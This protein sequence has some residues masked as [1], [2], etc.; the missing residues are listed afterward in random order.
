[1][2]AAA[3]HGAR[4]T[5][6]RLVQSSA[7][8]AAVTGLLF[9]AVF[10]AR[11]LVYAPDDG[12]G[13]LFCL[14][15]AF[16]AIRFGWRGGLASGLTAFLLFV[17]WAVNHDVAP[18]NLLPRLI[19]FLTL[20]VAVGYFAQSRNE[21]DRRHRRLW[22]LS[23]DA[24]LVCDSNGTV[25]AANS[26]AREL[27]PA[28]G[29]HLSAG[30][31]IQQLAGRAGRA[32]G[33][34]VSAE[35]YHP[36]NS[37]DG[38]EKWMSWHAV[39]DPLSAESYLV[40]RDVTDLHRA[41][42]RIHELLVAASAAADRERTQIAGELHDFVLQQL[43]MG[44]L[45]L[46][47]YARPTADLSVASTSDEPVDAAVSLIRAA[48]ESLRSIMLGIA[49]LDLEHMPLSDA[50]RESAAHLEQ[51]YGTR[52]ELHLTDIDSVPAEM[53]VALYRLIVEAMRNAQRHANASVIV[54]SAT[55]ADGALRMDVRD[56]GNGRAGEGST[57]TDSGIGMTLMQHATA[58]L[59]GQ[60]TVESQPGS[61]SSIQITIP[62][63]R[64][65]GAR[66][67]ST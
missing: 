35:T 44:L 32:P 34:P 22:E 58:S 25:R 14:P 11:L 54:V 9:A 40:G 18:A 10:A 30:T 49:P 45:A 64:S 57:T 23:A 15:V 66:I 26:S 1:M 6:T 16:S 31:A 46:S 42:M 62:L 3:T 33:T 24:M 55:C 51:L 21:L 65:A 20:G 2:T 27:H 50:L 56:D 13:L 61:G 38:G 60:L 8:A 7:A 36:A 12:I 29:T 67:G 19:V 53:R 17:I 5:A 59:A 48:Q 63:D 41:E 39:A 43:G 4:Q 28:I 47:G 52:T 37:S